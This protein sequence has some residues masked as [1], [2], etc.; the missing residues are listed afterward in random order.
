MH[1]Y[2]LS[3]EEF[4]KL[5]PTICDRETTLTPD[6]WSPENPLLGHCAVVSLIVQNFFGGELLRAS[7]EHVPEFAHMRSHYWN[8]LPDSTAEDFTAPQFGDRYPPLQPEVAP[9]SR[10]LQQQRR[11]A[12]PAGRGAPRLCH[13]RHRR[14]AGH[15][16]LAGQRGRASR[17]AHL[18]QRRPARPVGFADGD[19]GEDAVGG[20]CRRPEAMRRG[21]G[22]VISN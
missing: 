4:Q 8:R 14:D 17:V 15:V 3:H 1:S 22:E 18:P 7:L 9:R 10:A 5:L 12:L 2:P 6:D 13:P 16:R 19:G 21:G 11:S 20:V